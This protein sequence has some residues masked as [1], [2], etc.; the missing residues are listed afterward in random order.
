MRAPDSCSIR[1]WWA[2]RG[3]MSRPARPRRV[4]RARWY[5]AKQRCAPIRLY[6]S[7]SFGGI[8][9]FL[10]SLSPP[11][12]PH[13]F[14]GHATL[15][16]QARCNAFKCYEHATKKT[17]PTHKQHMCVPRTRRRCRRH[18]SW[19]PA[20]RRS[21]V[22]AQWRSCPP[23]HPRLGPPEHAGAHPR[24]HL[25]RQTAHCLLSAASASASASAIG[26][27]QHQRRRIQG[28]GRFGSRATS[29]SQ[30]FAAHRS[31]SQ[32]CASVPARTAPANLL[33]VCHP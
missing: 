31:T 12:C 25:H 19:R 21:R 2:P 29:W 11:P 24:H 1:F 17:Q 23:S 5:R 14:Y 30:K 27:R 32:T 7:F 28:R 6:S 33:G 9:I 26:G 20:S 4:V 15:L 8:K 13:A 22:R 10:R 3:P 18:R 16:E